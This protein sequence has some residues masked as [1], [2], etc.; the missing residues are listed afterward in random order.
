MDYTDLEL[1]I[2]LPLLS[3][4]LE[5]QAYTMTD[6]FEIRLKLYI[7]GFLFLTMYTCVHLIVMILIVNPKGPVPQLVLDRSIKMLAANG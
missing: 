4:V 2:P 6:S 3:W 7:L 1:K 5:K